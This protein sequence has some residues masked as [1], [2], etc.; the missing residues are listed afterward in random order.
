LRVD[1]YFLEENLLTI[2]ENILGTP[3]ESEE[4]LFK[5][6]RNIPNDTHVLLTH[7][8]VKGILDK[9]YSGEYTGSEALMLRVS[10]LKELR[11]HCCGHIH[12]SYGV[13][14]VDEVIYVNAAVDNWY[15]ED[16][17]SIIVTL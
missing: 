13:A 14:I 8:P 17:E 4:E 1:S 10:K 16:K 5:R 15:G 3:M 7:T 2:E 9:T 12:E 11:L 6:Y